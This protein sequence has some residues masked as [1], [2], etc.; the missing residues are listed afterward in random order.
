[1]YNK[2]NLQGNEIDSMQL[3]DSY[4]IQLNAKIDSNQLNDSHS[5]QLNAKID[6][7]Q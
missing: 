6:S 7:M 4:P 3:I 2:V 5:I 1:M